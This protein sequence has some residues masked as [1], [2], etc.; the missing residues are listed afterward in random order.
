M[1]VFSAAR[2]QSASQ[3]TRRAQNT[4]CLPLPLAMTSGEDTRTGRPWTTSF[5]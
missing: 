4:V 1:G 5:Y 2:V 3:K